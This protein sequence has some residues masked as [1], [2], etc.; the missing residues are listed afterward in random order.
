MGEG[1]NW[2][3]GRV[4]E[5][6][7]TCTLIFVQQPPVSFSNPELV[8]VVLA[9]LNLDFLGKGIFPLFIDCVLHWQWDPFWIRERASEVN[10]WLGPRF[11]VSDNRC[12]LLSDHRGGSVRGVPTVGVMLK[13]DL[14]R[15]GVLRDGLSGLANKAGTDGSLPHFPN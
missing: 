13:E 14:N 2:L 9:F 11:G 7:F 12:F 1:T 4:I 8:L 6:I 5:W 15:S 10:G 3:E